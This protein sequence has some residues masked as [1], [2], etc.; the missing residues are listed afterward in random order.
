[1]KQEKRFFAAKS[2]LYGVTIYD[3]ESQCPAFKYGAE[4]RMDDCAAA[5]LVVKLNMALR[6][7]FC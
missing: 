1:M 6:T 2:C 7:R 5:M 3:R 4:C